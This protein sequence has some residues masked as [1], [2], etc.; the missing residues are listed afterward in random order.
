MHTLFSQ[1]DRV[2]IIGKTTS[3]HNGLE[4][5]H[6]INKTANKGTIT[7]ADGTFK[8]PVKIGDTLFVS[9]LIYKNKYIIISKKHLDKQFIL[10]EIE[11][12]AYHIKDVFISNKSIFYVDKTIYK[13]GE[14]VTNKSLGLPNQ[15][16]KPKETIDSI[17][18]KP[19]LKMSINIEA[20]YRRINGD[21]K[22]LKKL[23]AL[24]KESNYL[25]KIQNVLGISFFTEELHIPKEAIPSFFNSFNT[26]PIINN[27]K[28]NNVLQLIESLFRNAKNYHKKE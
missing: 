9:G 7:I 19:G 27:Y 24:K 6:I 2:A 8:I 23:N 16:N 5:I 26:K 22:K 17:G 13:A 1:E 20:I 12:K 10:I 4:N 25:D 15:N 3:N 14:N 28:N 11:E 21:F 18:F